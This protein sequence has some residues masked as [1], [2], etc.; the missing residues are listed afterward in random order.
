MEELLQPDSS[1]GELVVAAEDVSEVGSVEAER[2]S[3]ARILRWYSSKAEHHQRDN[4]EG[5]SVEEAE[6]ESVEAL[7]GVARNSSVQSLR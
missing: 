2:N 7:A 6:D 3:S 1:V 4:S 5:V